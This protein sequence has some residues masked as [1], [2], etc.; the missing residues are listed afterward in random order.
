VREPLTRGTVARRRHRR[1]RADG[2]DHASAADPHPATI[3]SADDRAAA[4]RDLTIA[5]ALTILIV[6]R[7]GDL[8]ADAWA[9][10]L[11]VAQALTALLGSPPR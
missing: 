6:D 9:S 5:H 1:A 11:T 7:P 3:S 4:D 2:A 8:H 10:A